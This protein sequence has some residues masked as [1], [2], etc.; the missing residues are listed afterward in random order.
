MKINVKREQ[1]SSRVQLG[2]VGTC[3]KLWRVQQVK[4]QSRRSR[5]VCDLFNNFYGGSYQSFHQRHCIILPKS[6]LYGVYECVSV[7]LERQRKT[8]IESVSFTLYGFFFFFSHFSSLTQVTTEIFNV[9][10]LHLSGSTIRKR[11]AKFCY[12]PQCRSRHGES[13]HHF[14]KFPASSSIPQPK[15]HHFHCIF[16]Q[17]P[18][19]KIKRRKKGNV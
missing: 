5:W 3:Q 17:W 13:L 18:T 4:G 1:Q 8:D 15:L 10:L 9:Q 19:N 6:L 11:R 16:N 12:L 14:C 7:V 2:I